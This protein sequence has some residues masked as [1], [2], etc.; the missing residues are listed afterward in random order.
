MARGTW[1]ACCLMM[2]APPVHAQYHSAAEA[3]QESMRTG[4]PI[5]SVATSP[6]CPPCRALKQTLHTDPQVRAM[7]ESFVVLEMESSSSD[8]AA[9]MERFEGDYFGVP[10]VHVVSSD[11][12]LLYGRSGGLAAEQLQQLLGYAMQ[13]TRPAEPVIAEQP[14][15]FG[16]ALVSAKSAAARGDLAEALSEVLPIA[17]LEG[18]TRDAIVARAYRDQLEG[19]LAEWIGELQLEMTHDRSQHAAAYRLAKLF[20]ELPKSSTAR[21]SARE[22]ML[23]LEQNETTRIAMLQAKELVR[24]R[25][26][27]ERKQCSDAIARYKATIRLGSETPSGQYA[28][29]RIPIV[30]E[31]EQLKLTAHP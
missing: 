10:M 18:N 13:Q 6:T 2:L 15:D 28:R 3:M 14:A 27:E 23:R 30:R 7:L 11:G 1:M 25:Y 17:A 16:P 26:E 19:A 20:T 24:A 5:F 31:R 22:M 29:N 8:F 21:A 12:E 9:F 4:K